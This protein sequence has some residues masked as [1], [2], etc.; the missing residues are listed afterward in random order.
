[1][2]LTMIKVMQGFVDG[3]NEEYLL[4]QLDMA[5]NV[6][7]S[8][9]IKMDEDMSDEL[10]S[11]ED[12]LIDAEEIDLNEMEIRK[13]YVSLKKLFCVDLNQHCKIF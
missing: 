12:S 3:V 2:N 10:I 9:T 1:M 4:H 13:M 5:K 7:Q 6:V 8:D 11:N